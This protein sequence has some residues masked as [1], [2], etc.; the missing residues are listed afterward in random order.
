MCFGASVVVFGAEIFGRARMDL[1][2]DNAGTLGDLGE[3]GLVGRS[4]CVKGLNFDGESGLLGR[5]SPAGRRKAESRSML[6]ERTDSASANAL[7]RP[8][9]ELGDS[10]I[11]SDS[12]VVDVVS[13]VRDVS[14]E[15]V[16]PA[17]VIVLAEL[18]VST[19]GRT[20]LEPSRGIGEV[21]RLNI[22]WMGRG[23]S[24][25]AGTG[26]GRSCIESSESCFL[27]DLELILKNRLF[28]EDS[29]R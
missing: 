13:R 3:S 1:E 17:V 28:F 18:T 16:V 23:N 15:V 11:S 10:R 24:G 9:V 19:L 4:P 22:S 7:V 6:G 12:T 26:G 27:R 8:S 21:A 5:L 25:R 14:I 29:E 2:G 20:S